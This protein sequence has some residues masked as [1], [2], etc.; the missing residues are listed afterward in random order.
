M[1][2]G[3]PRRAFPTFHSVQ[4]QCKFKAHESSFF[5]VGEPGTVEMPGNKYTRYQLVLVNEPPT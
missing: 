4:T 1:H 5:H 3:A 2:S